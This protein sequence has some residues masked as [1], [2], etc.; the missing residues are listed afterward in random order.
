MTIHSRDFDYLDKIPEDED[1]RL[2]KIIAAD[3]IRLFH[4]NGG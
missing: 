1:E 2:R 3:T 4:F